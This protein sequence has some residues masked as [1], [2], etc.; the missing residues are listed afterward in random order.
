MLVLSNQF[1][2]CIDAINSVFFHFNQMKWR[3]TIKRHEIIMVQ[4][5]FWNSR[6]LF[7]RNLKFSRLFFLFKFCCRNLTVSHNW[8]KLFYLHF[9]WVVVII[10]IFGSS[11]YTND[12]IKTNTIHVRQWAIS[13]RYATTINW[14]MWL[15]SLK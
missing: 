8:T 9:F 15:M 2:T 1:Y 11:N 14:T 5:E 12:A 10:I 3:S 7:L 6:Q 13:G 4:F